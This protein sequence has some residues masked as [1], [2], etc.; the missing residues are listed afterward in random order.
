M[1][2]FVR[3]FILVSFFQA[4]AQNHYNLR[5]IV[6]DA[7][8]LPLAGATA[9]IVGTLQG[10]ITN[11]KGEFFLYTSQPKGTLIFS[12]MG[13]KTVKH[14]FQGDTTFK[15]QME[16]DTMVLEGVQLVAK[17]NINEI[18]ARSKTGNV[19][20]IAIKDLKNTPVA[21]LALALQGKTPGMRI[22]NRAELGSKPEI[23]IR[24]NS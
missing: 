13:M 17:Q 9:Q 22:I 20:T 6:T 11:D 2:Y 8:G 5:G 18:D 23:R 1:K 16:D 12:F 15:I 4:V 10:I 19:E 24:G 14:P 21:S 7:D 3:A